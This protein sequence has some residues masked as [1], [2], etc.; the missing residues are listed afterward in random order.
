[1]FNK[2]RT[3][4]PAYSS[5]DDIKVALPKQPSRADVA[6]DLEDLW[7]IH[8]S[9]PH[10]TPLEDPGII[11]PLPSNGFDPR[12]QISDDS[13]QNILANRGSSEIS[14]DIYNQL[15]NK[16]QDLYSK[17]FDAQKHL[18]QSSVGEIKSEIQ[19]AAPGAF[20]IYN[21]SNKENLVK[22]FAL[23]LSF[24]ELSDWFVS[25]ATFENSAKENLVAFF[26][27]SPSVREA[28]LLPDYMIRQNLLSNVQTFD[29]LE[30]VLNLYRLSDDLE[31]HTSDDIFCDYREAI[32]LSDIELGLEINNCISCGIVYQAVTNCLNQVLQN[33]SSKEIKN[34]FKICV[35]LLFNAS[36]LQTSRLL[37]SYSKI[38]KKL[39]EDLKNYGIDP[40]TL[41]KLTQKES[42]L[43][44][45]SSPLQKPISSDLLSNVRYPSELTNISTFLSKSARM[46]EKY[47]SDNSLSP[48]TKLALVSEIYTLLC[49]KDCCSAMMLGENKISE[50]AKN[51][52]DAL[53]EELKLCELP[54]FINLIKNVKNAEK[55]LQSAQ[56]SRTIDLL[57]KAKSEKSIS[58]KKLETLTKLIG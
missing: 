55:S 6:R 14:A 48:E 4:F 17:H 23:I 40:H 9:E 33:T 50:C 12:T 43:S 37:M 15:L 49:F 51:L 29:C 42:M 2:T 44:Q 34:V 54:N 11:V 28:M 10:I 8:T 25:E 46:L 38:I 32:V 18:T 58:D 52:Y 22:A 24:E 1:M 57:N 7:D 3:I 47:L 31:A 41:N 56:V 30:S 5:L 36:N 26:K 35:D 16:T 53:T 27:V 13:P 39:K 45:T 21:G 19:E 20:L